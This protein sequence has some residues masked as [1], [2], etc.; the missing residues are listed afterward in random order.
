MKVANKISLSF[1]IT[2]VILTFISITIIYITVKDKIEEQIFDHLMTAAQSR[3]N[4]L[5][6]FLEEQ[7]ETVEQITVTPAFT[8]LLITSKNNPAY[9][10]KLEQ[11]IETLSYNV[12]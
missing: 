5:E 1:L 6:T 3:A 11:T 10:Q 12:H 9:N 8:E 4:H 7:K 2:A